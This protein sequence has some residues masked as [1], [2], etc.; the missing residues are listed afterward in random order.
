[1]RYQSE[2]DALEAKIMELKETMNKV[3][4]EANEYNEDVR[5][6]ELLGNLEKS[7]VCP[8]ILETGPKSLDICCD[9]TSEFLAQ[10]KPYEI[11]LISQVL[12]KYPYSHI[13]AIEGSRKRVGHGQNH[14]YENEVLNLCS[15]PGLGCIY[16]KCFGKGT[17]FYYATDPDDVSVGYRKDIY[18]KYNDSTYSGR[19]LVYVYV[20][21]VQSEPSALF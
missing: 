6:K 9:I 3:Q 16:F 14:Y 20:M 8:V 5:T 15:T 4:S 1:M 12:Q 17:T 7:T 21:F 10:F 2:I 19:D 13:K 18:T 11:D